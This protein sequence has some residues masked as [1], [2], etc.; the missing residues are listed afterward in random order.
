MRNFIELIVKKP[1]GG[2]MGMVAIIILGVISLTRLPVDFLPDIERPNITVRTSYNNAGPE[3]VEKSVTRLVENAIS[4][5]N[6]IKTITSSSKEGESK[7]KIEFN[8]GS[9]LTSATADIREALDRIRKN[10]PDDADTPTV[11]KYSTDDI[12]VMEVSFYGTENLSALYNLVDNNVVNKIEQVGGVASADI[13][14]G[15]K[16]QIKVDVDMNRLQAYGLDINAIVSTL[17]EENQNLAGGQT[18][19]GVYEYTLR[20]TGEFKTIDDIGTVVVALKNNNTPI[21]LRDLAYIYE[22]YDENMDIVKV[23]GAPAVNISIN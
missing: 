7:V 17:G 20:T 23:N 5:V 18:Y 19:E 1:V 8:W 4:S 9:D 16:S 12:P 6:N 3:E 11:Y 15:I 2:C 10:L 22:G 13:N 21:K 14:G